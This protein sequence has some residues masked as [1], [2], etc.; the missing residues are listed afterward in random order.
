MHTEA[1]KKLWKIGLHGLF[2]SVVLQKADVRFLVSS[3]QGLF[4]IW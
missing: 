3:F 2:Q 1:Q 4:W